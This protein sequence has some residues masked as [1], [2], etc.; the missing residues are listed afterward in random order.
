MS[1]NTIKS[2]NVYGTFKNKSLYDSAGTTL[3][4]E[5]KAIFDGPLEVGNL[6]IDGNYIINKA[7]YNSST[8]ANLFAFSQD[9]SG[10]TIINSQYGKDIKFNMNG[11]YTSM[12][13]D[14]TYGT[15]Y[16]NA[17]L[18]AY[19]DVIANGLKTTGTANTGNII[20]TGNLTSVNGTFSGNLTASGNV[21]AAGGATINGDMSS[22]NISVNSGYEV[23]SNK[24]KPTNSSYNSLSYIGGSYTYQLTAGYTLTSGLSTY[25]LLDG[26]ANTIR[27]G[28]G[29]NPYGTYMILVQYSLYSHCDGGDT[30]TLID[31]NI[32]LRFYR[33]SFSL[34]DF[35][36]DQRGTD[37]IVTT[38]VGSINLVTNQVYGIINIFED[39][40]LISNITVNYSKTG[41]GYIGIDA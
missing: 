37:N 30:T 19:A 16:C 40:Y 2:T 23:S 22:R 6:R 20:N 8:V 35:Y 13:M 28:T 29:Y 10:N 41:T 3:V 1:V 21:T 27:F 18:I 24:F 5:A 9:A 11:G 34:N 32:N 12:W 26:S 25:T 17:G 4:E 38:T 33:S 39:G 36:F 14:H 31:H 15:L 7:I